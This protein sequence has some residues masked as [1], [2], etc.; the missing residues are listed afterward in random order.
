MGVDGRQNEASENDLAVFQMVVDHFK[1][2]TRE[3]WARANFFLVAHA[4]LFSAFV[5]VYPGLKPAGG[6]VGFLIPLLGLSISII[7]LLV[8]RGAIFFL[9]RWRE[10]V[11]RLDGELDRFRCYVEVESLAV[12]R[13]Y[14]S[15][16]FLT[17]FLPILFFV[18]WSILL[19]S[20]F[21]IH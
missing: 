7:W 12:K 9:Q 3:F 16:S 1:Q 4:G 18:V 14:M 19:L 15:P 11:I 8:M 17:Q 6:L 5:V 20:E 10:Q 21:L 2:D 13:P